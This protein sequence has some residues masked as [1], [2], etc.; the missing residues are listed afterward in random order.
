MFPLKHRPF[1]MCEDIFDKNPKLYIA[2]NCTSISLASSTY[3]HGAIQY[4]PCTTENL[5]KNMWF[6]VLV[7]G[8][9]VQFIALISILYCAMCVYLLRRRTV[10]GTNQMTSE[11]PDV[12][13]RPTV[14]HRMRRS[15]MDMWYAGPRTPPYNQNQ[16]RI[17]TPQ[18]GRLAQNN[19]LISEH[20]SMQS[21]SYVEVLPELP[22]P[23]VQRNYY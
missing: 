7:V 14:I 9:A 21:S 20:N 2:D 13:E 12:P 1:F 18:A 3:Y 10:D 8:N 23:R 17:K 11:V 6:W 19:A 15:M 5:Q 4:N 16:D 22:L